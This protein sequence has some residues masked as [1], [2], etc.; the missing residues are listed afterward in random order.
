MNG[1]AL[2]FDIE[3]FKKIM[4]E[5]ATP[6]AGW[7]IVHEGKFNKKL[8]DSYLK[9][10]KKKMEGE[11]TVTLCIEGRL[12]EVNAENFFKMLFTP[13]YVEKS[14]EPPKQYKVVET[15]DENTDILYVEA[16]LPF[17][18]ANRDFIQK[19]LH[20][21]NKEDPK[22]I[23]K[24]GLYDYEHNYYVL[25][26]ESIERDDFPPHEKIVRAHVKMNY[27]LIEEIP[28]EKNSFKFK[29]HVCQTLNG[30]L[31]LF[32]VNDIAPKMSHKMMEKMLDAYYKIFGKPE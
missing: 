26:I 9:V 27:W 24:L 14:G 30:S 8:P 5:E 21:S 3:G 7:T 10:S 31:P 22:V 2:E 29:T 32:F 18:M 13:E 15:I 1:K 19:R 16:A 25:M 17:P 20:I 6:E 4:A 23:K 12:Q 11:T 28:G